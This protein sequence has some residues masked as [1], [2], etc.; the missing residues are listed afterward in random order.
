MA[1]EDGYQLAID[2]TEASQKADG[3]GKRVDVE[4]LLVVRSPPPSPNMQHANEAAQ[5]IDDS[6][7]R[8]KRLKTNPG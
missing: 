6:G 5:G 7:A 2:L 8:G 3:F 4:Q 1:I